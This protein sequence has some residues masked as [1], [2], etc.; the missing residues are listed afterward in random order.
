MSIILLLFFNSIFLIKTTLSFPCIPNKN[1]P[2]S[3]GICSANNECICKN[4]FYSY[5]PQNMKYS[6]K[7]DAGFV[8]CNY[9]KIS[10]WI[11][12]LIDLILPPLGSY[13]IGKSFHALIKLIFL[14]LPILIYF[15]SFFIQKFCQNEEVENLYNSR[16]ENEGLINDGLNLSLSDKDNREFCKH[17]TLLISTG[18]TFFVFIVIYLIDLLCYGCAF[19]NDGNGV[20]LL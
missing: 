6:Y 9:E 20:P 7:N 13:Y 5:V 2:S 10:R 4:Q 8:Y 17:V 3:K 16:E 1:C 12:F 15:S 19:Y 18:A 11:P 14:L